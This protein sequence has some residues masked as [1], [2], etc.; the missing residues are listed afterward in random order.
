VADLTTLAAVKRYLKVS[1]A[2]DPD[3]FDVELTRLLAAVSAQVR[4]DTGRALDVPAA[5]RVEPHD[6]DG[7][8]EL[9]LEQYPVTAVASVTV[10]GTAIP[11]RVL[12]TDNGHVL[13][14]A[15]IGRLVLV[16]YTFTK[17]VQNVVVTYTAGYAAVPGDLEQ[18]VIELVALAF[19]DEDHVGQSARSVAGD[20]V[21]F[22]GG[23][24]LA[25]A[26]AILDSYRRW[27]VG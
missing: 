1:L 19:R 3:K 11:A 23:P 27:G 15:A 12:V 18:A 8:C 5:Q 2:E 22:R 7:G 26:S 13:A 16:G 9:L 24:Q 25:H 6:G 17:G 21:D 10:D 20:M 14:D 4:T